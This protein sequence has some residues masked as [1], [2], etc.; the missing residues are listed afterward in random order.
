M[1]V[2]YY[3]QTFFS[4]CDFPL[5]RELQQRKLSLFYFMPINQYLKKQ[6]IVDIKELKP[7]L[8]IYKASEFEEFEIYRDYINL[9]QIYLLNI[10]KGTRRIY[11]KIFWVYVFIKMVL[12][13]ADIFHF[14][15]QLSGFEKI[16]YKLPYKKVMTVHDPISHSCVTDINEEKDR[17]KAFSQANSYI[18]L[19]QALVND[20]CLKYTI[21]PKKITL[22]KMGE[23]EHLRY[24]RKEEID[25]KKP[26]ILFFGQITTSKGLEYLC[27]A[28]CKVHPK[29][30]E[31]NLLIA[32]RGQMYFDFT[33]YQDL[34]YIVLNNKYLSVSEISSILRDTLFVVLPYKDATQS[35]VVQTAFSCNVPLIVTNVGGLPEAVQDEVTGIVVPPNDSDAL[36]EAIDSLL[37]DENKLRTFQRNIDVVWRP[38]MD[39]RVIAKDYAKTWKSLI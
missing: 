32:G 31:V 36:A 13:K 5:I 25:M 34:E 15:W 33:P 7:R 35:G 37:S 23:F 6:G 38:K 11:Q 30:P 27:E 19:S 4:D 2:I 28:M 29:H 12:L 9:D 39:W 22:S 8:G 26:Y 17:I 24:V 3:S 10:P 14:T 21:S 1:R 16:L 20:F 18:L